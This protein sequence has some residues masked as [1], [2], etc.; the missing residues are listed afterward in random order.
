M[1]IE[2]TSVK[3]NSNAW[4]ILLSIGIWYLVIGAVVALVLFIYQGI[5]PPP[6]DGGSHQLCQ[7]FCLPGGFGWYFS[8]Y[9]LITS[10]VGGLFWPLTLLVNVWV[11]LVPR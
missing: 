3:K 9:N 4:K 11:F 1:S 5:T 6:H 10:L 7:F 8:W 2:A